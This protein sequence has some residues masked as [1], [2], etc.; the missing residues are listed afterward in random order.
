[1]VNLYAGD[2]FKNDE[3]ENRIDLLL[4]KMTLK[5]KVGQLN[6]VSGT[7]K[8]TD[9]QIRNG[10]IGSFLNVVGAAETNRLQRIAVEES[11]LGIPI[12]FGL[13]V[14]HGYRTIFPIPLAS[15][16]TWDPELIKRAEQVAAKEAAVSGIHW[17]F[18]PMVDIARDPRW[19]RIAEGH[20]EDPFLGSVYAK[21]KVE[22]FQGKDLSDPKTIV[23]CPKHFVAYGAAEAGRDYNSVD[24][25]VKMLREIYLP[26][27]KAALDAG[28]GT[29]MAAF[30]DLN[31]VPA[32]ANHFTLTD[33][34][35]HEWDFR[36]FVV[37][38]W[39]SILELLSHGIAGT[40]EEAGI[41]ALKA[42]V[43]MDMMSFI[44]VDRLINL[45]K[46]GELSEKLID[47]A[48]RRVLRIK[49]YL[50]LFDHP[51]MDETLKKEILLNKE[52]LELARDVARKSIV[53]LKNENQ[54]LPLKKEIKR[55]AVIGPLADSKSDMLGTWHCQGRSEEVTTVL[56]AIQSKLPKVK[57]KYVKG[58]AIQD[59]SKKEFDKAVRETK[60]ADATVLV[61]GEAEFMSG[62]A[63]SRTELALP[64][65][66][67]ALVKE[68]IKT[69]KPV[70]VVLMNG[71]PLTIPWIADNASAILEAWFLGTQSG[72][73]IA[74]VLFGDFNPSAKLAIS[75]PRNVGQI[76]IY[77]NHKNTGRPPGEEKFTSKYLD[78][79]VTPLYTF[80]FGLSYTNFEY[81]DLTLKT[82]KINK[83]GDLIATVKVKN[84]G[85]YDGDEV[86]QLYI[87]DLVAS[88]SRPVKE[89]KGFKKIHLSAGEEKNV[90]LKVKASDLGFYDHQSNY[91]VEPGMFK[92]FVGSNSVDGLSTNF[93][94]IEK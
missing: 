89:L 54:L 42:G 91:F 80:G 57:I 78:A 37:S 51:Y 87:K 2:F 72:P 8:D 1:M 12:I 74:D 34:L 29:F 62:E 36:G 58:C 49:Y 73:A 35:R 11:R 17:T 55:L 7:N 28:A 3:I 46:K 43:D 44:Y 13:D 50:G 9:E 39:T 19:G 83:S 45:V 64:G 6:Q 27:F 93:E 81:R 4:S 76:P 15:A 21:A 79:P 26:P 14:I 85:D 41:K 47:E 59:N 75:F 16:C 65:V 10:R 82:E 90:V 70:I 63:A 52:H 38:D 94:I 86:V 22:G 53:L 92:L 18:S 77:Y 71:R 30:N 5:E 69:G 40:P 61:V 31:G 20:G 67:L 60:K 33:I 88:M 24:M 23:S 32:S 25:S 68:L 56:K 84:V 48:V 66:Q